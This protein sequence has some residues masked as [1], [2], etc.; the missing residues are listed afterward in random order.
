LKSDDLSISKSEGTVIKIITQDLWN[1]LKNDII[2]IE[3]DAFSSLFCNSQDDLLKVVDSC[4]GLL[5]ASQT[6]PLQKITGYLAADL[7][8]EFTD[9]PGISA[10][11]NYDRG[12]SIY[13]VSIAVHREWQ[14]MGF[15]LALQT[16]C[17]RWAKRKGYERVT[18]HIARGAAERMGLGARVLGSFEN[19]YDTGRIFDYVEYATFYYSA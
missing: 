8:E 13:I 14:K 2:Q 16:E 18:A 6:N 11:L 17:L 12:N 3:E 4:T 5:L 7:L 10:D 19:W 15:G 9:V 1:R